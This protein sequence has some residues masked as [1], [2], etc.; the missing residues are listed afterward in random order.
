MPALTSLLQNTMTKPKGK[1]VEGIFGETFRS[2][3]PRFLH[4]NS[5]LDN[6][7]SINPPPS[8]RH[9]QYEICSISS[10]LPHFSLLGLLLNVPIAK[11]RYVRSRLSL[12]SLVSILS[13]TPSVG[14][15]THCIHFLQLSCLVVFGE[16]PSL[17][18]KRIYCLS[19]LVSSINLSPYKSDAESEFCVGAH[20]P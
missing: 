18:S 7:Q 11:L 9:K 6:Q 2:R 3:S 17:S 15:K 10:T 13:H 20:S 14:G 19:G 1:V 8:P 4:F 12:S 5:L 16:K